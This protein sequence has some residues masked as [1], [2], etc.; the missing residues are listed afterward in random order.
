MTAHTMVQTGTDVSVPG[1]WL[2]KGTRVGFDSEEAKPGMGVRG[3]DLTFRPKQQST[4]DEYLIG[5]DW[6]ELDPEEKKGAVRMAENFNEPEIR[7][8][9]RQIGDQSFRITGAQ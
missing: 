1:W 3:R 4:A 7:E 8:F 5:Q 9:V 2:V 6:S